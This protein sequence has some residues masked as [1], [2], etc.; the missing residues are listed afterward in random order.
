ML[1][2]LMLIF[3]VISFSSF[4]SAATIKVESKNGLNSTANRFI[5]ALSKAD[6]PVYKQKV[7]K[8][9]LPGGF[10]QTGKEVV[11]SNPFFGWSLGECHR[12]ERKDKPMT[13]RI[14]KGTSGQV[15]LEYDTPEASVNSFGVIECGN[16]MDK[17]QRALDA[18]VDAA[19]E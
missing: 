10:S 13:A 8:K 16:E 5:E 2:R 7:I 14:W 11:F 9:V 1:P 19:V 3:S 6:V 18:F 17:V 4:V 12:G 15:W